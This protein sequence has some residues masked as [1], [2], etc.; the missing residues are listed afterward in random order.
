MSQDQDIFYD[1]ERDIIA[2]FRSPGLEAVK[3]VYGPR[4]SPA[5]LIPVEDSTSDDS[6]AEDT[7]AGQRREK[8]LARKGRTNHTFADSVLILSI[9]PN[10]RIL[11]SQARQEALNSRSPSEE[12]EAED[13]DGDEDDNEG[14]GGWRQ[15]RRPEVFIRNGVGPMPVPQPALLA[16]PPGLDDDVDDFPM[17]DNP[18]T[19]AEGQPVRP[20][21]RSGHGH[22]LQ[23]SEGHTQPSHAEPQQADLAR[24]Q[25]NTIP[26]PRTRPLFPNLRLN[27]APNICDADQDD[28]SILRSPIL[29][30]YA[31]SPRDAHPDFTLPAMQHMS[32][33]RSS[34]AGISDYRMTLPSLKI[35]IGDVPDPSPGA[36][37]CPSPSVGRALSG[38]IASYASPASY[39][40]Y[41]AMSP[42]DPRSHSQWRTTTGYSTAS[43]YSDYTS[44]TSVSVG[45]PASSIITPSPAASG[46]CS[47]T[48]LPEHDQEEQEEDSRTQHVPTNEADLAFQGEVRFLPQQPQPKAHSNARPQPGNRSKPQFQRPS[49]PK[50]PPK[51]VARSKPQP[52][53]R[54]PTKP[55]SQPQPPLQPHT[56]ADAES[57]AES[58]V[59]SE[60][61]ELT[62]LE[63]DFDSEHEAESAPP[64]KSHPRRPSV[65]QSKSQPELAPNPPAGHRFSLGP[66]KCTYEGCNAPPFSTQYLLNSHMNVHSNMRTHFCPVKDCPRGYG[67]LGFKRKNEMIR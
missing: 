1:V 33:P 14:Q 51:P 60:L 64:S 53:P 23:R 67:G 63:S 54:P 9:D 11:A 21:P 7:D 42:P 15:R 43:T 27:L 17:I 29:G 26:P 36:F 40:A 55:E 8:S 61:S 62:E 49:R 24:K 28:D 12:A 56:Q 35:A 59:E 37:A 48:P 19:V 22:A 31:I 44:S 47:L 25:F 58:E 30:K 10:E 20:S 52:P 2:P 32:P 34:P 6:E 4:E 39:S 41:S 16:H 38:Q 66:Y 57:Q 65:S 46:P 5:P 45:T 18:A 3:P 50:P 13:E